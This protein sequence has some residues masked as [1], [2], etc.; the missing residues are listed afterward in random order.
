M[1]DDQ[2]KISSY[3]SNPLER[4]RR[5][6]A[7]GRDEN[8]KLLHVIVHRPTWASLY[9]AAASTKD[10]LNNFRDMKVSFMINLDTGKQDVFQLH[11]QDGSLN[12]S[13]RGQVPVRSAVNLLTYYFQ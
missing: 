5:F 4:E 9:N 13:V 11:N 10:F 2:L 8:G 12:Q 1:Y 6:L 7:V 3:D